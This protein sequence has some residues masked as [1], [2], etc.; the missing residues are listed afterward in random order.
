MR[1][2]IWLARDVMG[3]KGKLFEEIAQVFKLLFIG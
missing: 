2:I 1:K 3:T